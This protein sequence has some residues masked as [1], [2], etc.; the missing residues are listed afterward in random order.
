MRL[1]VADLVASYRKHDSILGLAATW[2]SG[3]LTTGS[4]SLSIYIYV[5]GTSIW[6]I[7]KNYQEEA[8]MKN[9]YP[10]VL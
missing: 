10:S 1:A 3:L 8:P 2:R 6:Y 7:G 9:N 4:L 5:C